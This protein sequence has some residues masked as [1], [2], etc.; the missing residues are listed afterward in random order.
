MLLLPHTSGITFIAGAVDQDLDGVGNK[1]IGQFDTR[2]DD[3]IQA[4]GFSA[5]AADKMHM[6]IM[7]VPFFAILAK[8]ITNGV[9]GCGN[10]M[11]DAFFNKGLQ[12]AVDGDPV[13]FFTCLAFNIAMSQCVLGSQEKGKDLPPAIRYA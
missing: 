2:G 9:V 5:V 8:G 13:K 10:G 3:V 12:G 7:M 11:D 6:V 4:D 1:T